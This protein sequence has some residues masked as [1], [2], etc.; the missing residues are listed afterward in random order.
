METELSVLGW[1]VKSNQTHGC[2]GHLDRTQTMK[3]RDSTRL[4]M[5]LFIISTVQISSIRFITTII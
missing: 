1:G 3:D 4:K 5:T 2:A